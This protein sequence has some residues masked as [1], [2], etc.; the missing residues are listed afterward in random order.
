MHRERGS[1]VTPIEHNPLDPQCEKAKAD[2]WDLDA[3]C[4]ICGEKL[5]REQAASVFGLRELGS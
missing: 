2:E 1:S 5:A 3:C 4:P